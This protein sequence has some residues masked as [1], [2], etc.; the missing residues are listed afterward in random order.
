[1]LLNEH[2]KDAINGIKKTFKDHDRCLLKM[3]CGTGKT[4]T[5]FCYC[6][7]Y[8]S[9]VVIIFPSL[10]LVKQ[11]NEDYLMNKELIKRIEKYYNKKMDNFKFLNI[12]SMK[13]SKNKDKENIT[14]D[15]TTS[16]KEIKHFIDDNDKYII[17]VTYQSLN[18]VK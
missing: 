9:S 5:M 8:C 7:N 17:S 18:K 13:E 1:M 11:F 15:T 12:C 14:I 16:K 3:F 6:L 2:Q 10:L 4:R